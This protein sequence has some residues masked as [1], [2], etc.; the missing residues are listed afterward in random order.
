[1]VYIHPFPSVTTLSVRPVIQSSID[2]FKTA[3]LNEE[4][5]LT[6]T[7]HNS[8]LISWR[9]PTY[10]P[11]Q[12]NALEFARGINPP[13]DGKLVSLSSGGTTLSQ[14]S[15]ITG[16]KIQARLLVQV[17]KTSSSDANVVSCFDNMQQSDEI[18]I[19]LAGT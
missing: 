2:G 3:C 1:M 11:G 4:V 7:V 17:V 12:D 6:C 15:V 19:H 18:S 13:G 16:Q 8:T 14:L 5:H 9:S 10:I